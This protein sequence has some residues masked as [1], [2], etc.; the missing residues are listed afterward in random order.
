[1][2][3]LKCLFKHLRPPAYP[4]DPALP[5]PPP[6]PL[7][8]PSPQAA[9]TEIIIKESGGYLN[10][11]KTAYAVAARARRSITEEIS[12]DVKKNWKPHQLHLYTGMEN[13]LLN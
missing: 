3:V 8:P 13:R 5:P 1:M 7:P 10:S 4:A 2:F 12:Q 11:V 9:L 6:S